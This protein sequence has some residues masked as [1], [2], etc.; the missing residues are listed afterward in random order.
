MKRLIFAALLLFAVRAHA[1]VGKGDR[2]PDFSLPTIVKGEVTETKVSLQSLRGKV[3]VVDFWAQWCEPCKK[4]LPLLQRVANDY[5]ARG[6]T[7]VLVNIDKSTDKAISL[8]R[9]L[10][11]KL[12][13]AVDASGSVASSFDPPKMPTSYVIDKN[14]IIRYVNEGFEGTRDTDKLRSQLNELAK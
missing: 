1:A 9:D 13:I 7:V 4:E 2:A 14:G 5:A 6:V 8:A 3:V 11:I 12:P 10:G